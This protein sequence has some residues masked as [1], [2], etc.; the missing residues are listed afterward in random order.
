MYLGLSKFD[1]KLVERIDE[2]ETFFFPDVKKVGT[3]PGIY[4]TPNKK[5][6]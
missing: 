1:H 3:K 6:D 2:P 4:S 5:E